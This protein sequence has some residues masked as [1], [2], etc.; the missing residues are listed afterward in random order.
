M[1]FLLTKSKFILHI[2]GYL[3]YIARKTGLNWSLSYLI[4]F[5][6]GNPSKKIKL[7][8]ITGTNGKT[9]T[10]F[11]IQKALE[12]LGEKT[13]LIGTLYTSIGSVHYKSTF[14]TPKPIALNKFLRKMIKDKC[15]Y[16]VME[17]S[18]IGL[19]ENRVD[20]LTFKAG[21]F[22][23]LTH[24]HLDFHKSMGAYCK[25][26]SKLFNSFKKSSFAIV[27]MDDP[28]WQDIIKNTK[29]EVVLYGDENKINPSQN[30]YGY[31]AITFNVVKHTLDGLTINLDGFLQHFKLVGHFNA[32]NI[33][34]AY[35]TLV[36]L[37]FEKNSAIEALADI[38][39]PPG[40]FQIVNKSN[41]KNI[42]LVI[43][44][45]AHTPDAL[46]KV[47]LTA[48]KILGG[49]IK[50]TLV[51]GCDGGSDHSKRPVM[52]LIAEQYADKIIL[53][54]DNSKSEKTIDICQDIAIGIKN[55]NSYI[56]KENRKT[57]IRKA[58]HESPPDSVILIA[59]KGHETY[60]EINGK[61]YYHSDIEYAFTELSKYEAQ[62]NIKN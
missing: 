21:V 61:K 24:D 3:F 28:Y 15:K 2:R 53:T 38:N 45:Y 59:G 5:I 56:I 43:V 30:T 44:D 35:V 50:L 25:A 57:A 54:S 9:T 12:N 8:G 47:L 29:A 46:E 10:S 52:G 11:L 27:N 26:K 6:Y 39:A 32:Y 19:A 48:R 34:A 1:K 49:D 20:G 18:S 55:K 23:N 37:G 62:Q 41:E 36:M 17:T 22:T 16:C 51:F 13:G 60:Q 40:R 42:P 4:S 7:I 33:A 14:T 31:S 58:L